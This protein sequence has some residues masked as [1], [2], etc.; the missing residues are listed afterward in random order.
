[1]AKGDPSAQLGLLHWQ[2]HRRVRRKRN[3]SRPR[4]RPTPAQKKLD[5]QAALKAVASLQ[6]ETSADEA[7]GAECSR[8]EIAPL[9]YDGR[10]AGAKFDSPG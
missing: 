3:R 8:D 1:M 2:D 7:S 10:W 6:W 9:H 5:R 4:T